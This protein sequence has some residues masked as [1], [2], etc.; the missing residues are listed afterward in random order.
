MDSAHGPEVSPSS[1]CCDP[2]RSTFSVSS[3]GAFG[4]PSEKPQLKVML[5]VSPAACNWSKVGTSDSGPTNAQSP[6]LA[7]ACVDSHC[8]AQRTADCIFPTLWST[9]GHVSVRCMTIVARP[10]LASSVAT[11]IIS[12]RRSGSLA[13]SVENEN[14]T[15]PAERLAWGI[16]ALASNVPER[17]GK[18]RNLPTLTVLQV[19]NCREIN[20]NEEPGLAVARHR[21]G[22][23]TRY[24]K[25]GVSTRI[26]RLLEGPTI[27][28]LNIDV[29]ENGFTV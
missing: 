11:G 2:S 19:A 10:R 20:P 5:V 28:E 13:T 3:F 7:F 17:D 21:L 18:D 29:T 25:E 26:F 1:K 15:A 8:S 16:S 4:S 14:T 23:S 6:D 24:A 12:T 22:L 27:E 9:A